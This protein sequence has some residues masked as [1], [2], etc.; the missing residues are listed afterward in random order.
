MGVFVPPG[1]AV[2]ARS[3]VC[4]TPSMVYKKRRDNETGPG[5]IISYSLAVKFHK[6]DYILF[7]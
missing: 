6:N 1:E 2:R 5:F 4:Y 3:R 7:A